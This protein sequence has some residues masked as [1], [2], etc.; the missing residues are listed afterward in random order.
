MKKTFAAFLAVA[1][2]AGSLA[3]TTAPAHAQRGLGAAI[4]GGIIGGA[5]VGGAIASTRPAYG[6]PVYMDGPPPPPGC[7]WT[8]QRYWDGYGW[9]LRPIQVCN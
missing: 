9:Q 3:L 5:M 2:I 8:R 1:T 7:Y 6:A 4:A